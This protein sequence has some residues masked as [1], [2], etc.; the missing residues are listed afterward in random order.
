MRNPLCI[1]VLLLANLSW[2][3]VAWCPD[4]EKGDKH[5]PVPGGQGID[6]CEGPADESDP[7]G[8]QGRL[9]HDA[10]YSDGNCTLWESHYCC[11]SVRA[12]VIEDYHALDDT[13]HTICTECC[14][15]ESTGIL[16]REAMGACLCWENCF[17]YYD[18]CLNSCESWE[19]CGGG[20]IG[21]TFTCTTL[22]PEGSR[23][24]MSR[25]MHAWTS[26]N[27]RL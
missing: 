25:G 10:C 5:Y 24:S 11:S 4:I 12:I 14:T 6:T 7:L 20:T 17:L 23:Q 9:W 2:R 8:R 22:C 19:L 21:T 18:P 3:S 16:D 15:G 26:M 1:R 27:V 13:G